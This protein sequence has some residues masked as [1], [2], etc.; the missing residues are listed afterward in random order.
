MPLESRAVGESGVRVSVL[1][2]ETG[3][4]LS[5]SDGDCLE[6][7][8]TAVLSGITFFEAGPAAS[9]I[10]S[11][12]SVGRSI[13]TL[14]IRDKVT[15]LT[16]NQRIPVF[17]RSLRP[18]L[19]PQRLLQE[20]DESR[21]RLGTD[22]LDLYRV[23]G[24][25]DTVIFLKS[26][27]TLYNLTVKGVIRAVGLEVQ[28]AEEIQSCLKASPVHFVQKV[29]SFFERDAEKEILGFCR[30]KKIGFLACETSP[31][32]PFQ[33]GLEGTI[34]GADSGEGVRDEEDRRIRQQV[35]GYLKRIAERKKGTAA[36]WE[37]AWTL[38]RPGVSAA[39]FKT[40][41]PG[42]ISQAADLS[43]MSWNDEDFRQGESALRE[44]QKPPSD[45]SRRIW[46]G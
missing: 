16:G 44:A 5:Q 42:E 27:E 25:E 8:E 28:T 10:S 18:A 45:L 4:A 36:Q 22:V 46:K 29:F 31:G 2:L 24:F 38:S 9:G 7:I 34:I 35:R 11:E 41:T 40:R 1:G 6:I 33:K 17:E 37:L 43:L 15:L 14:N 3:E 20:I 12:A 19:N 13:R 23:S 30:E 39:L 26:L 32:V 21:R